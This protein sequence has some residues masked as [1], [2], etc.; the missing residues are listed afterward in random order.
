MLLNYYGFEKGTSTN[1]GELNQWLKHN[2]GYSG[3]YILFSQV[4][5]Y[6]RDVMKL[7]LWFNGQ[8]SQRND[9]VVGAYI[10]NGFP[11]ILHVNSLRGMHFV[12]ANSYASGVFGIKDPWSTDETLGLQY[13]GE[14]KSSRHFSNVQSNAVLEVVVHSQT[15]VLLTDSVG[16]SIGYDGGVFKDE[17]PASNYYVDQISPFESQLGTMSSKRIEVWSLNKGVHSLNLRGTDLG[18]FAA[19]LF[20]STDNAV[21]RKDF[22]GIT[23][24]GH[25]IKLSFFVDPDVEA[26]ESPVKDYEASETFPFNP[27]T[28]RINLPMILR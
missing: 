1:P 4:A 7:D 25:L 13:H 21:F 27:K 3:G 24:E 5:R 14:Y 22:S 26:G 18:M 6:G 15:E 23:E 2:N 28:G 20:V 12:V 16:R 19:T 17:I 11:V 8:L 10:C 9:K